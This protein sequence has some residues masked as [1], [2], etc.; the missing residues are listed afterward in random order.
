MRSAFALLLTMPLT[1]CTGA[2]SVHIPLEPKANYVQV[3]EVRPSWF[4]TH[5]TSVVYGGKGEIVGVTG[6]G[7][8]PVITVPLVVLDA[9]ARVAS[10]YTLGAFLHKAAKEANVEVEA[11]HEVEFLQAEGVGR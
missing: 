2:R 7:G 4:S 5:T 3:I 1:A 6:S 8:Q 9:A 10:M 11:S